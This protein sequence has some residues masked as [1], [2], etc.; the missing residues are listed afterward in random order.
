[1]WLLQ[2]MRQVCRHVLSPQEVLREPILRTL[3]LFIS[4]TPLVQNHVYNL[5]VLADVLG[6]GRHKII[7]DFAE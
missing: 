3:N 5:I 6:R 1:M 7:H 2:G 4:F